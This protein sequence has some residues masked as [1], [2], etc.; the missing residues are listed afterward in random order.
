MILTKHE[1][2]IFESDIYS[3]QHPGPSK[4]AKKT[5]QVETNKVLLKV[6]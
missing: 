2:N 3:D 4:R 1:W 6:S 5:V